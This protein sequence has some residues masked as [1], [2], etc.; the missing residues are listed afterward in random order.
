[1]DKRNVFWLM[2]SFVVVAIVGVW[3]S[4]YTGDA[5]REWFMVLQKPPLYPPAA[6]F[7]IAWTVLYALMA[8]AAWLVG[9]R[10][11]EEDTRQ[12]HLALAT[13]VAMLLLQVVWCHVFFHAQ[14]FGWAA[15][16]LGIFWVSVLM[17]TWAFFRV[18]KPA[19]LLLLPLLGWS[20]FALYLSF[21]VAYYH[22]DFL[23]EVIARLTA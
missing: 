7:G 10:V 6:V 13:Y 12:A 9:Q 2:V 23:R 19:G 17:T 16:V 20:T 18:S 14:R 21:G 3:S 8:V 1:M 22:S 15:L 11:G 4:F 5:Q